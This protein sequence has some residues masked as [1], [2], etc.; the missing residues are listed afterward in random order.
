VIVGTVMVTEVRNLIG[1][2][3][4]GFFVQATPTGPA[5]FAA[6]DPGPAQL[7]RGDLVQFTAT[8]CGDAYEQRI[9]TELTGLNKVGR[10][11]ASSMIQDVNQATDLV[12]ELNSYEAEL[13]QAT[14]I[15]ASDMTF[16]GD[17]FSA[18]DVDTEGLESSG[19][20]FRIPQALQDRLQLVQGCQ[21]TMA[22]PMWRYR[23]TAQL[24][25]YREESL[26]DVACPGTLISSAQATAAREVRVE[27]NRPIN[28]ATLLPSGEQFSIA[29]LDIEGAALRAANVV[30]LS[31]AEHTPNANYLL[32]IDERLLDASNQPLAPEGRTAEFSGFEAGLSLMIT[33]L[34]SNVTSGCDRV[35]LRATGSGST[36]GFVLKER[37][38]TV[39]N[40]PAAHVASGDYIIVHFKRTSGTCNPD[41]A[42]SETQSV[43]EHATNQQSAEQRRL[44]GHVDTA[45]DFW[46]DDSGITK[47]DNV[48]QVLNAD[49]LIQDAVLVADDDEGTAAADSERAARVVV[50]AG[51]WTTRN[52][53]V[54]GGGFVDN[55]FCAHAVQG[56]GAEASDGTTSLQRI[57]M[58]D[59][60]HAGDW[61]PAPRASSWGRAN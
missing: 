2:D 22:G 55:D 9:I 47:T 3:V 5:L 39:F 13:L 31:T 8:A 24:S 41:A 21:A 48:F 44:G 43:S 49:G 7:T 1:N 51:Q 61:H 33:E 23:A 29:G 6:H 36:E 54:P 30:M 19:L 15:L 34:T 46:S 57:T 60:N 32:T 28:A 45:W 58:Q 18:A 40:F 56:L 42:T 16:A 12:S 25:V 17:G 14:V 53:D 10:G 52:G 26:S 50:E 35:E 59:R 4:A 11:D 37:R 20:K 27:F 38:S